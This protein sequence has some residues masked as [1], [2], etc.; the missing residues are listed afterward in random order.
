MTTRRFFSEELQELKTKIEELADDTQQILAKSVD[1]LY[2]KDTETAQWIINNDHVF[3]QKEQSINETV[4]VLIAKQQ[5][6][7]SDLRRLIIAIKISADLERM[8]DHAKNIAKATLHLGAEHT[9]T[10][11]PVIREMA[12]I[13]LDMVDIA[14]KA[15]DHED[16]TLAR[17]LAEKDDSIDERYGQVTR[18][19]LEQTANNPEQIQHIMQMAFTSRYIERFADHITNI[20]ESI[21]YL[22]KGVSYDLNE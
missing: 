16:I 18:D 21:F 9:I 8:A 17:E 19:L 4:I 6:V 12:D 11:H 3:N 2:K 15:Y 22:V 1:A 10:I 7:A 14:H 13:A 20:G 5:P